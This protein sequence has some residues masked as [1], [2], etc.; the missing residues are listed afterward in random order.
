MTYNALGQ[1]TQM[2]HGNNLVTTYTYTPH[3]FR[4]QRIQT[5]N[6]L[7]LSYAYDAVGNV[8]SILDKPSITFS[9]TFSA[10]SQWTVV[11][12]TWAIESDELS[13]NNDSSSDFTRR[14]IRANSSP[15]T[16]ADG[17]VLVDVKSDKT[18][19]F[20][21][22]VLRAENNNLNANNQVWV[23][24]DHR[25]ESWRQGAHGLCWAG[26]APRAVAL[27]GPTG[28]WRRPRNAIVRGQVQSPAEQRLAAA[29]DCR[30]GPEGPVSKC[31]PHKFRHTF[32]ITYLRSGGDVFTL[33]ALLGHGSLD[34]VQHYAR[35]AEID[36]QQAHRRASP[37]DNWRL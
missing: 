21:N 23:L 24:L 3:N 33:Q 8:K 27:P 14:S 20:N 37:A 28:R 5:G 32:A 17:T 18:Y 6:W 30:T 26:Y 12:G 7:D 13:Q 9:D 22:V 19:A 29:C 34:M 4:L 16:F 10:L 2:T 31:H 15:P 35:I 11:D 25:N 1:L 36:I